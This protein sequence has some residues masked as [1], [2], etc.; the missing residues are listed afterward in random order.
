MPKLDYVP[1]LVSSVVISAELRVHGMDMQ[2]AVNL[3]VC[4]RV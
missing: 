3:S 1:D 2:I 4:Q